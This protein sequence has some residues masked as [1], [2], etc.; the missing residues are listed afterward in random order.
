MGRS[1]HER[2]SKHVFN[3][4]RALVALCCS[5]FSALCWGGQVPSA[6]LSFCSV[7]FCRP[8]QPPLHPLYDLLLPSDFGHGQAGPHPPGS[9]HPAFCCCSTKR[10]TAYQS[11]VPLSPNYC[12]LVLLRLGWGGGCF[13]SDCEVVRL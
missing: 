5:V 4:A 6:S 12:R 10:G 13:I 11:S 7:V 9:C 3:V 8:R 1:L 2:K